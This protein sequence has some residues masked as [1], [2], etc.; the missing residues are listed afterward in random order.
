M[1]PTQTFLSLLTASSYVKLLQNIG[2]PESFQWEIQ[3]INEMNKIRE[4]DKLLR[5]A[6]TKGITP[7]IL[8]SI[9]TK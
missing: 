8:N 3:K 5:D 6:I 2:G 4:N 1:S 7:E 9:M